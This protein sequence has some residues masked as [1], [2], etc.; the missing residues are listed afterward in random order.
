LPAKPRPGEERYITQ[1]PTGYR[2]FIP[3]SL[4]PQPALAM[5]GKLQRLLSFA[6]RA[7][8]RLDG[9]VLTRSK[10]CRRG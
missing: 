4:P 6:D 5:G 9:S 1:Q 8:V 3:A 7:L 10:S 2:A